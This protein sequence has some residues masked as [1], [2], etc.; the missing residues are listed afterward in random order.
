VNAT[1]T[2]HHATVEEAVECALRNMQMCYDYETHSEM[3]A[4][5]Q[6]EALLWG[7]RATATKSAIDCLRSEL[8][9]VK[10]TAP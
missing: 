2:P 8:A 3:S 6:S 7:Q 9:S 1:P 4:R 5:N 10:G